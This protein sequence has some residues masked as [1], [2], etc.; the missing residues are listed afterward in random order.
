MYTAFKKY[1]NHWFK[2]PD[3]HLGFLSFFWSIFLLDVSPTFSEKNPAAQ[4][5]YNFSYLTYITQSAEFFYLGL[6]MF[7][8]FVSSCVAIVLFCAL[9][10]VMGVV[11]FFGI[12]SKNMFVKLTPYV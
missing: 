3:A 11:L 1:E 8:L 4:E 2:I 9:N 6:E 10:H 12:T 5:L 7:S